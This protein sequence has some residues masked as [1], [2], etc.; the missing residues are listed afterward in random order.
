MI[1]MHTDIIATGLVFPESPRWHKNKLWFSDAH[2][3]K[4]KSCDLDGN[5]ELVVAL[6]PPFKPSGLG[7][8]PDGRLL[9]VATPDKLMRLDP[10]GLVE[11]ADLSALS[12]YGLNDMVVDKN[13]N[14]YIGGLGFNVYDASAK[15][16]MAPIVLVTPSGE[17]RIVAEDMGFPN[18]CVVS[19]DGKTLIIGETLSSRYTAF[20]IQG[21]G[22]LSN[23]RVWAQFDERGFTRKDRN[24]RIAPDGCC[25]DEKGGIW[26]AS[27][28]IDEVVRSLEGG[29]ITHRIKPSRT[30]FACM[31]GGPERKD[32]FIATGN[33]HHPTESV[34]L[35]SGCIERVSVDI[36]GAG[37][38]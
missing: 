28:G 1:T 33:S 3:H 18:G 14:A 9:I 29:E 10:D 35:K 38:P 2:D 37:I 16:Q 13:G 19:E 23:R 4:V 26:I 30:P 24:K 11:V 25:M 27:P 21:D 17:T 36:A 8:L 7:F 20:D 31:L 5:V 34:A 12:P 22:S 6:T 32:L 15:P